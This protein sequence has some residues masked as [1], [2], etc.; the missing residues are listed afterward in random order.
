MNY[1][2]RR[3]AAAALLVLSLVTAGCGGSPTDVSG[4]VTCKGRPLSVGSV[5]LIGSNGVVYG[6]EIQPDGTYTIPNVRTGEVKI[7]VTAPKPGLNKPP[8]FGGKGAERPRAAASSD[9][10]VPIEY[11]DPETSGLKG[12]VERGKPLDID[13]P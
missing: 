13:I 6:G 7:A 12:T 10:E 9:P 5:T 2:L 8:P 4:K 3:V 1:L 11:A